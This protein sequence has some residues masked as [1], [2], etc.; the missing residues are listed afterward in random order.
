MKSV[1]CIMG[2]PRVNGNSSV[3]VDAF[4]K[5]AEAQ[6]AKVKKY[7]LSEMKYQ[8]CINLFDCKTVSDRCGQSDDLTE[9]LEAV[10]ES[11]IVVLSSPVYF[12]NITGQLKT[13]L[14]RWFSFFVPDYATAND[15][16]RLQSGKEIVLIQTQGEGPEMYTDTLERYGHSFK[17]MGFSGTHFIQA[18]GVREVGDIKNFTEVINQASELSKKLTS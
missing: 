11:D 5:S 4:C 18:C 7:Q 12:T 14:D 10:R 2:S 15:K 1:V 17:W 13:C 8:G 6:G 3:L 9:V 16:S